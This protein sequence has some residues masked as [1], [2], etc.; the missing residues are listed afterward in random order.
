MSKSIFETSQCIS[1]VV[2]Y[3][4]MLLG[5][6]NIYIFGEDHTHNS[7]PQ[8]GCTTF[9]EFIEKWSEKNQK[10]LA[11]FIE[12]P[13][14]NNAET[15]SMKPKLAKI[16]AQFAHSNISAFK[17]NYL[18]CM[19]ALENAQCSL[20][21]VKARPADVRNVKGD[22]RFLVSEF[23]NITRWWMM[24]H[25]V[26]SPNDE[27]HNDDDYIFKDV[28]IPSGDFKTDLKYITKVYGDK[29]IKFAE[30][31]AEFLLDFIHYDK[32]SILHE[33]FTKLSK[34]RMIDEKML[35]KLV[36]ESVKWYDR[37]EE[38]LQGLEEISGEVVRHQ[39]IG[40]IHNIDDMD[41][42]RI[43]VFKEYV[44]AFIC[45][46]VTLLMDLFILMSILEEHILFH[47]VAVLV[48]AFHAKMYAH[49]IHSVYGGTILQKTQRSKCGLFGL[50]GDCLI[51]SE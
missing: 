9:M 32:E 10:R 38:S 44:M 17:N 46:Y 4:E 19:Y 27:R 50:Y 6:Q 47:D 48:G 1:G 35:Q 8:N 21:N 31:P 22:A 36:R 18:D 2:F 28:R 33:L 23:K 29:L 40:M 43:S 34:K 20:S 41:A 37:S 42:Q 5:D 26:C 45:S 25:K 49:I 3:Q 16:P 12:N 39:L 51:K 30:D 11:L 24:I 13:F 14:T 15:S 7:K